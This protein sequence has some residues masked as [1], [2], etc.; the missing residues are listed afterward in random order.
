MTETAQDVMQVCLNGH[1]ITD[2]LRA[3]PEHALSRCDRCGAPTVHRCPTC[4]RDLPGAL[5][6]LGL[7]PIG[8]PEP[9]PHCPLCGAAFPWAR[10]RA[11]PPPNAL[12]VLDGLLRRLPRVVR[13]LRVRHAERPAFRVE[14]EHDLA[15][16]VR[17]LLPLCFD[18]VRP[19]ARTPSYAPGTRTDFVLAPQETAVT[20][21]HAT[22]VG[23]E[24][25]LTEQ[26]RE[27]T[28]YY[29]R[30]GGVGRLFCLVHDPEQRV[31]EPARFEA[32]CRRDEGLQVRCVVAW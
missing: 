20:V 5:E 2:R 23:C 6:A 14:D 29:E 13:Q 19:E 17:A 9:P 26:L 24:Q 18:D 10:R 4:G 30:R 12:T 1:V 15:D 31:V 16:L 22:A 11:A 7:E 8:K 27:D 3:R 32:M 25:G 28:A 21:K